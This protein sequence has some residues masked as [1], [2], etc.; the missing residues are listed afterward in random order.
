MVTFYD[1]LKNQFDTIFVDLTAGLG[2]L[3]LYK[4]LNLA[5]YNWKGSNNKCETTRTCTSMQHGGYWA[6]LDDMLQDKLI[7]ETVT[8]SANSNN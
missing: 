1:K 8:C 4:K 7:N 2:M 3:S 6:I 5:E